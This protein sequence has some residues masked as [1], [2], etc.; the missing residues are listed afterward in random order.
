MYVYSIVIT[1]KKLMFAFV[2]F[3]ACAMNAEPISR[4]VGMQSFVVQKG[5]NVLSGV[6]VGSPDGQLLAQPLKRQLFEYRPGDMF[7]WTLDGKECVYRFDG[8]H[9]HDAE[10]KDADEVIMPSL[11]DGIVFV[12]AVDEKSSISVSGQLDS[13]EQSKH[14]ELFRK[15]CFRDAKISLAKPFPQTKPSSLHRNGLLEFGRF[16]VFWGCIIVLLM[17]LFARSKK[18]C[19]RTF[20]RYGVLIVFVGALGFLWLA[21][22]HDRVEEAHGFVVSGK[23][24]VGNGVLVGMRVDGKDRVAFLTSR[25]VVTCKMLETG[26]SFKDT[27]AEE[28]RL[29]LNMV[30]SG[31]RYVEFDNIDPRR[32]QLSPIADQDFAWIVLND[33]E[34]AALGGVP[35]YLRLPTNPLDRTHDVAHER[36]SLALKVELGSDLTVTRLVAPVFGKG[37]AASMWYYDSMFRIPVPF[38]SSVCAVAMQDS[39]RLVARKQRVPLSKD[40]ACG[41]EKYEAVV[42]QMAISSHANNS[43]S[44][45]FV[46]DAGGHFRIFGLLVGMGDECAFF[47]TLDR[48][49]PFVCESLQ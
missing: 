39:G 2:L 42:S 49:L 19:R 14:D 37:R 12:R 25:S 28:N 5:T 17:M 3:V 26:R 16:L 43:G 6:V 33:E 20:L 34:I 1:M 47:Q 30:G 10:G 41:L 45:V 36:D 32:W 44:P 31:F 22:S 38:A 15:Q 7:V 48:I 11:K 35:N 8:A 46:K 18:G 40:D 27:P 29:C 4:I 24:L 9:W 13:E 21:P 23:Y